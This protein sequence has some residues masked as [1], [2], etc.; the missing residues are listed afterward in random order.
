MTD[1]SLVDIKKIECSNLGFEYVHSVLMRAEKN[2]KNY[3]FKYPSMAKRIVQIAR[4]DMKEL[5][6]SDFQKILNNKNDFSFFKNRP[7]IEGKFLY[8]DCKKGLIYLT[9]FGWCYYFARFIIS[10]MAV[11]A[12]GLLY[13]LKRGKQKSASIV[14][15][16]TD[17]QYLK[18]GSPREFEKFCF[19][20]PVPELRES[21]YYI[22]SGKP[23]YGQGKF[24]YCKYPH[25]EIVEKC[26]TSIS[27]IF[28]FIG[29]QLKYFLEFC[30]S[31]FSKPLTLLLGLDYAEFGLMDF[32]N[33]KGLI[34]N[35]FFTQSH[36]Y[37]QK[38]WLTDLPDKKFKVVMLWY[39][40]N[41]RP[42][43]SSISKNYN[44]YP[45]I[46]FLRAD[47]HYVWHSSEK[48]WL[49]TYIPCGEVR[50]CG[51]V[52]FYTDSFKSA[53]C[54]FFD[55]TD[56]NISIFDIAP[57]KS[58]CTL[59][60]T[61][62]YWKTFIENILNLCSEIKNETSKTVKVFLKPKRKIK[63]S[64]INPSYIPYLE[65]KKNDLVL[66][67]TEV[68]VYEL[69]DISNVVITIP[70]SSPA[71]LCHER[72]GNAT[73][74]DPSGVFVRPEPRLGVPICFHKEELKKFI[75]QK[76]G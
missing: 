65:S 34:E 26:E 9:Y 64:R 35:Y 44:I 1:H 63:S 71:V 31:L 4:K 43:L 27:D 53:E 7:R 46:F 38:L 62:D 67:P 76:I 33:T 17:E 52:L 11:T 50:A 72:K 23:I 13:I 22:C 42:M 69:C 29:F 40:A 48:K 10:W 57:Y 75:Y 3:V 74:Y 47:I 15:G 18:N 39:S 25:F 19:D 12:M 51:P 68:S 20:G 6:I 2:L 30:L 14:L 45:E 66:L 8:Y 21:N 60:C 58:N 24:H 32:L 54:S 70:F 61:F 55:K 59:F 73:Y 16:L 41:N 5:S 56:V 37:N 36:F 28:S 49:E